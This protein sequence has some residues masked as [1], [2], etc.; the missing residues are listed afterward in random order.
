MWGEEARQTFWSPNSNLVSVRSIQEQT[1][2]KGFLYIAIPDGW[3][4]WL[5]L[6]DLTALGAYTWSDELKVTYPNWGK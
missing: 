2:L 4:I 3:K 6:N 1:W 5:G